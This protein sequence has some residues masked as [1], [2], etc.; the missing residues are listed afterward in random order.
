MQLQR[1]FKF[2]RVRLIGVTDGFD[3]HVKASE[4]MAKMKG[5]MN[6]GYLEDFRDKIHRGLHGQV[7]KGYNA[8]GRCYGYR[9]V[10]ENDPTRMKDGEPLVLGKRRAIDPEQAQWVRKIFEW[11][12]DGYSPRWIAADLNRRG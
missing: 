6:A 2:W 8:G 1:R 12:A 4:L 5:W 10:K 7:L 3:N 11:Y 9:H